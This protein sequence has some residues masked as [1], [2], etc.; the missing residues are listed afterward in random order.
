[1]NLLGKF[2]LALLV[3]GLAPLLLGT[4]FTHTITKRA[5]EDT[6]SLAREALESQAEDYIAAIVTAEKLH[7]DTFVRGLENETRLLS[8]SHH[9]KTL[10]ERD[11]FYEAAAALSALPGTMASRREALINWYRANPP[12]VPP[13][14]PNGVAPDAET[15]VDALSPA[16]VVLQYHYLVATRTEAAPPPPPPPARG[17]DAMP[18][19]DVHGRMHAFWMEM[20]Q[21]LGYVDILL[22]DGE[23]GDVVY[24]AAKNVDFGASL[25]RGP[26]AGT[27]AAEAYREAWEGHPRTVVFKDVAPYFPAGGANVCFVAAPVFVQGEKKGVVL[28]A[29]GIERFDAILGT[30]SV[31]QGRG[32]VYLVGPD[33][34]PRGGVAAA[35]LEEA[36]PPGPNPV[37][38]DIGPVRTVFHLGQQGCGVY[39]DLNGNPALIAFTPIEILGTTWALVAQVD[40]AEAFAAVRQMEETSRRTVRRMLYMSDAIVLAAILVLCFVADYLAKP[41]VRP[42]RSTVAILKGMLQGEDALN[43]RLVVRGKDEVAELASSFNRFMDKVQMLYGSLE[44][45]VR[46][47]KRAQEEVE[48]RQQYYKALIEY[49]PDVIVVLDRNQSPRFVSPSFERTLGYAPGEF[50]GTDL[51]GKVH[52]D[53]RARV[54]RAAREAIEQPGEPTLIEYRFQHKDGRWVDVA[55]IGTSRLE[56]ENI[57]GTVINLRDV[58]K[59]KE[60]ERILREYSATLE[61]DVA[62]RTL[63]LERN[64]DE[65]ARALEEL[66]ATQNQLVLNEKMASLGALT[67]GIAHEIKNPLNFVTN[68]AELTSELTAELREEIGRLGTAIAAERREQLE[69]LLAAIEQNTRKIQEHGKRADNI[70][71]AM[72]LHS[73]GKKDEKQKVDVNALLDEYVQLSYHGMRAQDAAFNITLNLEFDPSLPE[74][75]AVPQDLARVFLNILNNGCFAAHQRKLREGDGFRPELTV[76]TSHESDMVTVRIRDN[77]DGI[78]DAIRDKIFTPFFTTKPAGKGTGLGLSISFDIVVQEHHGELRV[79]ST[80]GEYTEFILRLPVTTPSQKA[81]N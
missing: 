29:F 62:E 33:Y 3:C 63:Q 22:V 14:G 53:D 58:T 35:L 49:A 10:L 81:A 42:L 21:Q 45:E 27:H 16:G 44:S 18:Y 51:F 12:Q 72:L 50:V 25:V 74:V 56:D 80:P 69:E 19:A 48:R 34:Q 47:R 17:P 61:R 76:A 20:L 79:E 46:E 8:Q 41:I 31:L 39:N 32:R 68:F 75:E 71:R 24:S 70:V 66:Q 26:L 65:L 23:R 2:T 43:Q 64:R 55:A 11:E 4:L 73:R 1:M 38:I 7:L 60:A 57:A 37:R 59:T 54:Q 77:G 78:P 52:P 67:A 13:A 6:G 36:R 28:F 15:F 30:M 9:L 40:P 5:L